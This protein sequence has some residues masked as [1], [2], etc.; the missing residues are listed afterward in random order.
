MI[1]LGQFCQSY[2]LDAQMLDGSYTLLSK[3][4]SD[5]AIC[6][7][8]SLI[9]KG[10]FSAAFV[11]FKCILIHTWSWWNSDKTNCSRVSKSLGEQ[12]SVHSFAQAVY[13]SIDTGFFP[14]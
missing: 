12:L 3:S 10:G 8:A 13:G 1:R 14:G 9:G 2:P 11:W 7:L 4:E 5:N 6:G